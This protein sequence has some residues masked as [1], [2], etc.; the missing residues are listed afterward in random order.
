VLARADTGTSVP[1]PGAILSIVG[2]TTTTTTATDGR[3]RIEGVSVGGVTV[4]VRLAGYRMAERIVRVRAAD[5]TRLDIILQTDAQMLA[6]VR[7]DARAGD[8]ELF[9]AKPN[10]STLAMSAASMTGVPAVGEPDVIRLVQLLPGIS[11]RNDFNTGLNVRGGEADQNLVLLDGYPVYNPF[12]LGGLFSTFMDATVGGIELR[13]GAFPARYGGRLSSVLEV[14]SATETRPGMHGNADISA[15]GATGRLAGIF[16][17]GNGTWSFAARRTY[18]DATTSIFTNNIFPYHFSDFHG[19]ATYVLPADVHV[20]VTGYS[21]KDVLRANLADFESDSVVTK[22]NRGQWA[23]DWGNHVLGATITKEINDRVRLEQKFSTSSFA[24]TLDLGDGGTGQRSNIEDIRATGAIYTT[25]SSHDISL[26]YDVARQ[27]INY[28][29]GSAQTG[30]NDFDLEQRPTTSAVW[31]DDMWRL[32]PRWLVEGGLRA[33]ALSNRDWAALSPRASVKFFLAEDLALTAGVGRVTQTLHSLTGDGPLRYFDI[34]LA[35]DSFI[36]VATAWHYVA[37]AEKRVHDAGSVRVEGYVKRYDRVLEANASEDPHVRGDEFFSA[38]GLAYG[39]DMIA[40][41]QPRAGAAGWV[42]YS[43][44]MSTRTLDGVTWA[45]GNDRRHDLNVVGTWTMS[46]YQLGARFGLATGT[47]YTPIVGGLSRRIYDPSTDQW[48]T[49]D[50]KI[51]IESIG[52]SLNS[53]RYPITQRLDLNVSRD[54]M[55]RGA[56]VSPYLS[57]ANAYNAPNVF[58]YLY[59]YSTDT[60][61]RRAISQ[62]PILPSAGVRVAF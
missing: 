10:I 40:R 6:A 24:T 18:A 9:L 15:L 50:P 56:K 47:P 12:H 4:R 28:T 5:T 59:K 49:G 46:K 36:P 61:T 57:V 19:T 44:G 16:A 34:W 2:T 43:Y 3:Y 45:P 35:S 54:F 52:S 32:S 48:G 8:A 30:S 60:P 62:F 26:G 11:A 58:V 20:A 53:A 38:T 13:S 55:K 31:I 41:W 29:S 51:W 21:G 17:G 1:V 37:G 7:T 39:I 25:T 42:S 33:E 22:S 14:T 23:F 27:R